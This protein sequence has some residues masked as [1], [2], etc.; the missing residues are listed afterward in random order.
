MRK[1]RM[2]T[3]LPSLTAEVIRAVRLE[4]VDAL[5]IMWHGRYPSWFEDGREALGRHYGIH[6]LDFHAQ[7][8]VAPIKKM[9]MEFIAP[10]RY[11]ATCSIAAS[12]LWSDAA[13]MDW[14]YRIFSLPD[15]RLHTL[16]QSTQLFVDAAG[17]LLLDFPP[18]Y[19]EFRSRWK[20]GL[21]PPPPKP[22]LNFVQE[23]VLP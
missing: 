3:S 17:S 2:E 11:G 10:L 20:E 14:E 18:F 7:G 19:K 13:R 4:E 6:Y 1:K 23:N 21:L 5:G 9:T 12:L 16:A 15:R 22:L 8:V